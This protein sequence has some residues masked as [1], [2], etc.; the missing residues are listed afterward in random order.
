MGR[1][2]LPHLQSNDLIHV[3]CGKCETGAESA[4]PLPQSWE[5]LP[6]TWAQGISQ[7]AV[8]LAI[9]PSPE[10]IH[11]KWMCLLGAAA[12]RGL[13]RSVNAHPRDLLISGDLYS[14]PGSTPDPW[15]GR[16]HCPPS[17]PNPQPRRHFEDVDTQTGRET[18]HKSRAGHVLS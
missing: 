16:A 5:K 2:Q 15:L 10:P 14:S 7:R 1:R 18:Q 9:A 13:C 12:G 8:H 4:Q 3:K 11:V 6:S 17:T